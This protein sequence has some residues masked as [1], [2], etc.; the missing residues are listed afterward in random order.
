MPRV[1][2]ADLRHN[3]TGVLSN[4][5]MPLGVAYMKAVLDRDLPEVESRL[6]AY[7]DRL[8]EALQSDPP[9]VLMLSNYMWNEQLSLKFGALAR[10]V[11]PD[12]TVVMGGPNIS[13]EP[14]R[15]IAWFERHPEID[16][17]ALGEGDFL[18]RELM[19]IWLDAGSREAFLARDLPSSL[20]RTPDGVVRNESWERHKKVEEIPSPWLTGVLDPFFDG[21]LAPLL[22]TNRG[23]PFTCTFCVQ[24]TRWYTKVHYFDKERVREEIRYI[25]RRIHDVCPS[26]GFLRVADPNYGMYERDA[27]ISGWIGEAQAEYGW[28]TFIDATTGKNRPDRVIK[29]L[30]K[31]GGALV[32]YQ[33]VQSL[34][35]RTLK[36]IKRSNI[37]KEAYDQIMIHVRGRGLRSL[38]DLILGLPGETLASHVEGIRTLIDSGTHELH[39][40]Q[41]ML[42]KGSELEMQSSRDSAR[43]DNRFRVLP[44]NFGIYGGEMVFDMD[45]IVVAT[46]TMT[47]D[48]YLVARKHAL[49][50]TIFQNNSWFEDAV[51]LAEHLGLKRSEW[52][53]AVSEGLQEADGEVGELV[54]RFEG[55]TRGE[56]FD[57]PEALFEFYS[58]PENFE[59]L[60]A[61]EIGDNL[62]YKYRANA[63]F[64]VWPAVCATGMAATR[65]LIEDRALDTTIDDF[66]VFWNDLARFVEARH[67]HGTTPETILTPARF[68]LRY[69]LPK[70][71]AAGRPADPSPFRLERP[72]PF[73]ASLPEESAREIRGLFDVWT[74]S[75]QGLTKGVTRIR[76]EAQLRECRPVR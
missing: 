18:V 7:P 3:Y 31:T 59:K 36:N 9:D 4:D 29:S 74:T 11:N 45:E 75:L 46:E 15:Q 25:A 76:A 26:M 32:L 48:D 8:W 17:Y 33:A 30:E 13:I 1:Y 55:E 34:D 38:S 37:S 68:E 67:A 51:V 72:T 71:V 5:C 49:A 16:V 63:S 57:S 54:E 60:E 52:F 73:E 43:M 56:L 40:F 50:S 44:K 12:V 20:R 35:E 69:D 47:F 42:L 19:K 2:L 66:G 28:P 14:E 65:R 21:K 62:M 64:F 10:R 70:W 41:A 6:F 24:G 39:L 22:E 27:E 61:G 58:R 53:M 23:C